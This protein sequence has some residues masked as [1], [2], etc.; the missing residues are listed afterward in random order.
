MYMQSKLDL[1]VFDP[2]HLNLKEIFN[3]V[4]LE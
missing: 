2:Y 4:V 1:Y 3:E